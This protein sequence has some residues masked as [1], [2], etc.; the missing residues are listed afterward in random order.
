MEHTPT[1]WKWSVWDYNRADPTRKEPCI[2]NK[3]HRIALVDSDG[4]NENPYTIPLKEAEANAAFIVEACNNYE[5]LKAENEW[6]SAA[7]NRYVEL[8]KEAKARATL[9]YEA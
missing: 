7:L 5:A 2:E 6:L 1:P 4:G 8:Y 3:T 9:G